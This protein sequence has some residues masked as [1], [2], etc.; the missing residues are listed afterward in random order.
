[1]SSITSFLNHQSLQLWRKIGEGSFSKVYLSRF[2]EIVDD[3]VMLVATKVINKSNVSVKFVEKFLPR[4]LD[5]LFKLRHPFIVRVSSTI[6]TPYWRA[7]RGAGGRFSTNGVPPTAFGCLSVRPKY[8][9]VNSLESPVELGCRLSGTCQ[10]SLENSVWL[11]FGVPKSLKTSQ[12][13]R[14]M[15]R[16]YHT[17]CY[18]IK[19]SKTNCSPQRLVLKEVLKIKIRENIVLFWYNKLNN[20]PNNC[21]RLYNQH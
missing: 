20:Y 7:S 5:V 6:R 21:A 14:E 3:R 1:M 12:S 15:S 11:G 13:D 19:I 8:F 10:I 9:L 18:V 17:H 2:G 4:E 16:T